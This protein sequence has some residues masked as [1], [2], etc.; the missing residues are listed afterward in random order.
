MCKHDLG[1]DTQK[2]LIASGCGEV[3]SKVNLWTYEEGSKVR[4]SEQLAIA[5]RDIAR[6]TTDILVSERAAGGRGT[7]RI[8]ERGIGVMTNWKW[9]EASFGV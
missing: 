1:K 3:G 2:Y 6:H 9:T 8:G 5:R 7:E 4:R